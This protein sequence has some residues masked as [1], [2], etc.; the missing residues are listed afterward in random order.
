[1]QVRDFIRYSALTQPESEDKCSGTTHHI[2]G[3]I[4]R[5]RQLEVSATIWNRAAVGVP[6]RG[7][8]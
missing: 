2:G 6:L 7:T 8:E 1:M 4:Y 3:L 5:G